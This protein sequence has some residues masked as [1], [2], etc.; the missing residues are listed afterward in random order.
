MTGIDVGRERERERETGRDRQTDRL[1]DRQRDEGW[2]GG[3]GGGGGI[4]CKI[5]RSVDDNCVKDWLKKEIIILASTLPQLKNRTSHFSLKLI[6]FPYVAAQ[7]FCGQVVKLT[8]RAKVHEIHEEK[9]PH[10]ICLHST[11][12]LRLLRGNDINVKHL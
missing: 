8:H 6:S 11:P 3:G 10:F 5:V 12:T 9:K 1:T 7:P 2:G 4:N